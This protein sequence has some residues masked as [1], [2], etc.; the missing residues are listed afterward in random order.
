MND[1][2]LQA[3]R[4]LNLL[5]KTFFLL[6]LFLLA[7]SGFSQSGD[8]TKFIS[9]FSGN[10][11]ATNNGISLI[12]SF[13]LGK[14]AV[15]FNLSVGGDKLSFDPQ[16]RFAMEGK[17]WSFIFWWRYQLIQNEKFQVRL[18]VHPALSFKE[19]NIIKDGTSMEIIRVRRYLAAELA[20]NFKISKS[21]AISP[22]YLYANGIENDLVQHTQYIALQSSFSSVKLSDQLNFEIRP[23]I[24]LLKMDDLHGYYF[25][26]SFSLLKNNFPISLSLM[27]N[28]TIESEIASDDFIWSA[29]VIYSFG[30]KYTQL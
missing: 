8:S 19:I 21:I 30:K 3:T 4:N 11:S 9:H 2:V 5:N 29:S 7:I 18:G 1:R 22:Y 12:P 25:A 17:P 27:I 24:Y 23:Q 13:N 15:V 14:P 20:P 26:S 6:V 28:K 10:I 16:L